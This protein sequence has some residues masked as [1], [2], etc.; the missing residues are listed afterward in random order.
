MIAD[1]RMKRAVR[2]VQI[3]SQRGVRS[4]AGNRRLANQGAVWSEEMDEMN[5]GSVSAPFDGAQ[6]QQLFPVDRAKSDQLRMN[7]E[8]QRAVISDEPV[9]VP[10]PVNV[11][12]EVT[13]DEDELANSDLSLPPSPSNPHPFVTSSLPPSHTRTLA[14]LVNHYETL[15]KLVDLGMDLFHLELRYNIAPT[16]AKLKWEEDVVP[17]AR[18]LLR[19]GMNVTELGDYLT[20]NPFILTQEVHHLIER[21]KYLQSKMFTKSDVL[22][23]VTLSRYWLNYDAKLIDGRLGWLQKQFELSGDQLR[24]LIVLEPRVIAFGV[25]PLQVRIQ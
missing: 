9:K 7:N 12:R 21:V 11:F 18:F 14:N 17:R 4:F 16:L 1:C 2:L 13:Y 24:Q 23:I 25:G 20:R 22:R 3:C 6:R 19:L 8:A 10:R 15:Q 5:S